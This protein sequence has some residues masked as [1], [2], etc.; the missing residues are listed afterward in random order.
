MKSGCVIINK[1]KSWEE[2]HKLQEMIYH[3]DF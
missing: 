1:R 3:L 2:E